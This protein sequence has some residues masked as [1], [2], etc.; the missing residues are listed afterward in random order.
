MDLSDLKFKIKEID[1]AS[2]ES[3][4]DLTEGINDLELLEG[5]DLELSIESSIVDLDILT[6]TLNRMKTN[7]GICK[8]DVL[9]LESLRPRHTDLDNFLASNPIN[10]YTQTPSSVMLD[11]SNESFLKNLGKFILDTI[12]KLVKYI[13]SKLVG[14]YNWILDLFRDTVKVSTKMKSFRP[15]SDYIRLTESIS[16]EI[17]GLESLV[18]KTRNISL[19]KLSKDPLDIQYLLNPL[20]YDSIINNIKK[21]LYINLTSYISLLE[22]TIR[23]LSRDITT[24]GN[25]NRTISELK[26]RLTALVDPNLLLTDIDV[27]LAKVDVRNIPTPVKD[28]DILDQVV[29]KLRL[30][31]LLNDD[32]VQRNVTKDKLEDIFKLNESTLSVIDI[33]WVKDYQRSIPPLINK[34]K[35]VQKEAEKLNKEISK[36][37]IDTNISNEIQEVIVKINLKLNLSMTLNKTL[38]TIMTV[39]TK[40]INNL[41]DLMLDEVKI[42]NAFFKENKSRLSVG[43]NVSLEALAKEISK[44]VRGARL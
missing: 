25:L 13:W 30:I 16:G 41:I 22:D 8:E 21:T 11:V 18:N 10:L 40:S 9:S 3:S 39:R 27:I 23:F 1:E 19:Q 28:A 14:I 15:L 38:A 17:L 35:G 26:L 32:T 5:D 29:S 2:F 31:P 6:G 43:H 42:Y 34:I 12:F 37:K 44:S 7:R 24:D 20:E 33:N 36:L 4:I